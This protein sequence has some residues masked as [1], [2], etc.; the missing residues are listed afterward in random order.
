VSEGEEAGPPTFVECAECGRRVIE[1]EAILEG[2]RYWSD[3]EELHAVCP[4]CAER[5]FDQPPG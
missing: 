3:G 4:E 2:W 5:E 1:H